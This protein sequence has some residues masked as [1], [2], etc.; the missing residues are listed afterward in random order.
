MTLSLADQLVCWAAALLAPPLAETSL[1]GRVT[2]SS[3]RYRA[4]EP[5][6]ERDRA[7]ALA[8]LTER[9]VRL[10]ARAARAPRRLGLPVIPGWRDS[11]LSRAYAATLALRARGIP[12][13]LSIGVRADGEARLGVAAHAWVTLD[14]RPLVDPGTGAFATLGR[15]DQGAG[16]Q[17]AT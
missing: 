14:G 1:L 11:C 13:L 7:A 6:E 8:A 10:V 5:T 2:R 16:I 3:P 17:P 4:G 9:R 15:G 12:A